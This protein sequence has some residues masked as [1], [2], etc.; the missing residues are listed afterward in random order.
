[1]TKRKKAKDRKRERKGFGTTWQKADGRWGAAI[2]V[3]RRDSLTGH[4]TKKRESTTR[5]TEKEADASPATVSPVHLPTAVATGQVPGCGGETHGI[6]LKRGAGTSRGYRTVQGSLD[7]TSA[8][9]SAS[10]P[11]RLGRSVRRNLYLRWY[12][13]DLRVAGRGP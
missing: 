1:M 4:I 3:S 12:E 11:H 9:Q 7:T 13:K 2:T 10:P 8:G 5:K 6:G